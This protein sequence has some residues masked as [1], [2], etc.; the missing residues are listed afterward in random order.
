MPISEKVQ[1]VLQL[2]EKEID[3]KN[4]QHARE[5]TKYLELL[6]AQIEAENTN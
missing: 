1:T 2:I 4:Y 5:L 3:K 6:L